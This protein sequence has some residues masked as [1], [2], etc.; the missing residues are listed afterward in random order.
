MKRKKKKKIYVLYF[1]FITI[2]HCTID[3]LVNTNDYQMVLQRDPRTY[4]IVTRVLFLK[5]SLMY[6]YRIILYF[7]IYIGDYFV[8]VSIIYDWI[9]LNFSE[10]LVA[11]LARV[12]V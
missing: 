2:S 12:L 6:L 8:F 1:F 5:K 9:K 7:T 11:L 10:N 4:T 3:L